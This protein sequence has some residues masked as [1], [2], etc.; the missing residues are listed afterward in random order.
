M[1]PIVSLLSGFVLVLVVGALL[2]RS[3]RAPEQ[4]SAALN[5]V[6]LNVT[7]P[8]LIVSIV[9]DAHVDTGA[10]R[11]LAASALAL[12]GTAVLTWRIGLWRQWSRPVIGSAIMVAS[13]CNTAFLGIPVVRAAFPL[14]E[15]SSS[16]A[17]AA[18]VLI[19]AGTTGV[20]LW[21]IGV[22]IAQRFGGAASTTMRG[23]ALRILLQP[24]TWALLI[25]T[26]LPAF[27]VPLSPW[28]QGLLTS[29]GVLTGPL[30]FLS[31]GCSLD[32]SAV[33]FA[34]RP[35]LWV[36]AL[37]LFVSP[38]LAWAACRALSAPAP[39]DVVSVLQSAMPTAMVSSILAVAAGCDKALATAAA[40]VTTVL[41]LVTL[42][43]WS[44]LF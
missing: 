34:G 25:A 19:D 29:L 33:R 4:T 28:W 10:L 6:I 40:V 12:V 41:A 13:F 22:V 20:L 37:K 11:A 38:A 42:P 18:A 39:H 44:A 27:S 14:S 7:L 21:T 32:F 26:I 16:S 36:V 31:L 15:P 9:Y 30:V 2:R 23:S 8:C 35:L 43:L 3:G 5:A 24:T 1:P 17:H